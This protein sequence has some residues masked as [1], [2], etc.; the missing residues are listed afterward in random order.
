LERLFSAKIADLTLDFLM[1]AAK[2]DRLMFL[3]QMIARYTELFEAKQGLQR[4]RLILARTMASAEAE[5]LSA[6]IADILQSKVKCEIVV[7]PSI[8]GGLVLR[9]GDK[10]IDN[11]VRGRLNRA[12]TAIM[13]RQDMQ[14]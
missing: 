9:Y 14:G 10:V 11:S 3:P 5:K 8:M 12:I 7:D 13:K 1:V 4:V 2:H 6:A